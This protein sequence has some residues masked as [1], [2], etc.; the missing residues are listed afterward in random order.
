MQNFFQIIHPS[1]TPK[2]KTLLLQTWAGINESHNPT[3]DDHLVYGSFLLFAHTKNIGP[4]R[5]QWVQL[6]KNIRY[7]PDKIN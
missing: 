4:K 6:Q 2:V 5:P 1:K 7:L 3:F